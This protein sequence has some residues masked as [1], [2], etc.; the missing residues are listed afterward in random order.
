MQRSDPGIELLFGQLALE[1]HQ[2]L[3]P[4]RALQMVVPVPFTVRYKARNR[5][6]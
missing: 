5:E 2:T 4:E 3:L 1:P 6:V